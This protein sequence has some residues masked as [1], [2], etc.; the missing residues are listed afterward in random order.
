[1]LQAGSSGNIGCFTTRM[2][3]FVSFLKTFYS[4]YMHV[5]CHIMKKAPDSK[6]P[7]GK[8]F[9]PVDAVKPIITTYSLF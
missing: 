4:L 2:T 8:S 5:S 1:M 7:Y 3:P 9:F 6:K